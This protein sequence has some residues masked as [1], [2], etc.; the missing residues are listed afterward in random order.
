MLKCI[1]ITSAVDRIAAGDESCASSSKG[2][3]GTPATKL[4]KTSVISLLRKKGEVDSIDDADLISV[5][6]HPIDQGSENLS[7]RIEIRV[8]EA[9]IDRGREVVQAG[10]SFT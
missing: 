4:R 3:D 10:E 6:D 1:R 7:A 8:A 2:G 9:R 5:N